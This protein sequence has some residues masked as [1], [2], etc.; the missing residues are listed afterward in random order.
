MG[1][2]RR[3]RAAQLR[4]RWKCAHTLA[5]S[6]H[7]LRTRLRRRLWHSNDIMAATS[8]TQQQTL[9]NLANKKRNAQCGYRTLPVRALAAQYPHRHVARLG[10]RQGKLTWVLN[11][12]WGCKSL[13]T[14][15][16]FRHLCFSWASGLCSKLA[17][18]LMD[19]GYGRHHLRFVS[20][21]FVLSQ[22]W[23]QSLFVTSIF[24]VRQHILSTWVHT[25]YCIKNTTRLISK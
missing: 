21:W 13:L 15:D 1:A 8:V 22:C 5:R 16:A 7:T 6:A 25:Q 10:R 9:T 14:Y 4:M 11:L 18:R 17:S 2:C 19:D 12:N 23:F 3:G 20:S 24:S